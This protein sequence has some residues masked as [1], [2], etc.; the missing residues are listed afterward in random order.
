MEVLKKLLDEL[1][2]VKYIGKGHYT[3]DH[4][5]PEKTEFIKK[6]IVDLFEQRKAVHASDMAGLSEKAT[7][8]A[9]KAVELTEK[10]RLL[11]NHT[12]ELH[13]PVSCRVIGCKKCLGY[14]I[15]EGE[16]N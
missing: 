1:V 13:D 14:K 9:R 5:P 8:L 7:R 16:N 6:K 4:Q 2:T 3:V 11:A 15:K 12:D 10:S